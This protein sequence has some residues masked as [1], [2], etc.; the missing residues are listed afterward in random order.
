MEPVVT[1]ESPMNM[2]PPKYKAAL[3]IFS[4][5]SM[6][7]AGY[8]IGR[9]GKPASDGASVTDRSAPNTNLRR[10]L[11]V[12][13]DVAPGAPERERSDLRSP[14]RQNLSSAT[15]AIKAAAIAAIRQPNLTDRFTQLAATLQDLSPENWRGVLEAFDEQRKLFGE[16]NPE[17]WEFFVRRAGESVG[18]DAMD[19]FVQNGNIDAARSALTGWASKHPVEALNWLGKVADQQTNTA[20]AGAAMRGLAATEP[21]LALTLLEG[22]PLERRKHYTNDL[23]ASIVRG[24]G[25]EQAEALVNGMISRATA[26][27]SAG[28]EYVTRMFKDFA[29]LKVRNAVVRGDVS[30]AAEWVRS[31][32]GQS[33]FD[34]GILRTA[35]EQM[36][37]TQP[38][39]TI[40]WL[41]SIYASSTLQ[42]SLK[43]V[44][45]GAAI[46]PWVRKDGLSA[47]GSWLNSNQGHPQYDTMTA[48]YT[49]LVLDKNPKEAMRVAN[50]IKD[51]I[52]RS[53][54]QQK[55]TAV[56]NR[57]KRN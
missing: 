17:A 18:R 46:T 26:D 40:A 27:G 5:A 51:P 28:D 52:I 12:V 24:A 11:N 2:Y 21:D 7:G 6:F 55:I 31:Q 53:T 3:M 39:E 44:G 45:Y 49:A 23:V 29:D 54:T 48:Q 42:Q 13:R 9:N 32:V 35:A 4:L 8:F 56:V 41:D 10:A 22:M 38:Q 15:A 16:A 20:I 19:H 47:V 57:S 50:T 30:G 14:G 43:P 33:Y 1:T 37:R 34:P 25:I 36:A